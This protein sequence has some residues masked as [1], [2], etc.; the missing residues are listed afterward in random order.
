MRVTPAAISGGAVFTSWRTSRDAQETERNGL[1]T[2]L[3]ERNRCLEIKRI[4][5]RNGADKSGTGLCL[6]RVKKKKKKKKKEE[7]EAH[8]QNGVGLAWKLLGHL[9]AVQCVGAP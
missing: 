7:E 8:S 6:K 2:F 1:S 3:L 5:F 4:L 9:G